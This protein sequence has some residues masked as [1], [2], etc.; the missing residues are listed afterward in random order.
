M[1]KL[2]DTLYKKHKL[3]LG[4]RVVKVRKEL[5]EFIRCEQK[6]TQSERERERDCEFTFRTHM[7]KRK[8]SE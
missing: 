7:G 1:Y 2:N 5:C 6:K 4:G 8:G 3:Y